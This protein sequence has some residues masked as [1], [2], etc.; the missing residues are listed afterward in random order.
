MTEP[1][2]R[3]Q[4]VGKPLTLEQIIKDCRDLEDVVQSLKKTVESQQKVI[5]E[6]QKK[7]V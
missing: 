1:T 5:D 2:T 4:L 6:L 3:W 7:V